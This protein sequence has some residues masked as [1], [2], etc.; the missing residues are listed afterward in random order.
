MLNI[1]RSLVGAARSFLSAGMARNP[2]GDPFSARADACLRGRRALPRTGRDTRPPPPRRLMGGG[3]LR[4]FLSLGG[5]SRTAR[6]FS[7]V[8]EQ[9]PNVISLWRMLLCV[10]R[11]AC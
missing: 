11:S 1:V 2:K 10:T 8:V 4:R 9:G 5:N 7:E 6:R 3:R